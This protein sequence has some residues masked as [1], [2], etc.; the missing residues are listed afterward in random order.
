MD[1]KYINHYN[2]F[3]LSLAALSKATTR[4]LQDSFVISGTVQKFTL[5]FDISWKVMKDIVV[6]YYKISDFA[7]GSP[8]ECLRT[9]ASV[10]LISDDNWMNMLTLRNNLTHDYN[11]SLAE[12]SVHTILDVYLPLFNA[13]KIKAA[14]FV[15]IE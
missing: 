15:N 5:T 4:D 8:R 12:S 14:E 6:K 2:S 3:C 13:F 9:A 1:S 11:G 7:S 10:S